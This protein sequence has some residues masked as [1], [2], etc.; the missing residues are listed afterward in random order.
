MHFKSSPHCIVFPITSTILLLCKQ[1]VGHCREGQKKTHCARNTLQAW[2]RRR[3]PS[4]SQNKQRRFGQKSLRF[5]SKGLKVNCT[6]NRGVNS[7]CKCLLV[8]MASFRGAIQRADFSTKQFQ[9]PP[10]LI[11]QIWHSFC[12]W[13]GE[14]RLLRSP[15]LTNNPPPPNRLRA[16]NPLSAKQKKP[17]CDLH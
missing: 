12:N 13:R 6:K 17:V 3:S 1:R 7:A 5:W 4:S 10:F 8:M 9:I 11:S 2:W 14:T 15:F 16:S